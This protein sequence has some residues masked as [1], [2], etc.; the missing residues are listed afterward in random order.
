[1]FLTEKKLTWWEAKEECKQLAGWLVEIKS[2]EQN[3]ALYEEARKHNLVE[4]WIGLSDAG[5]EGEWVWTSGDK[6][7]FLNWTPQSPDNARHNNRMG[8]NCAV[9]RTG[10]TTPRGKPWFTIKKW[11][12]GSC[13]TPVVAAI[14]Q[15]HPGG[16]QEWFKKKNG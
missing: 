14:C 5:K 4:A 7:T 3:D 16:L 1:M 6:A 8:E 15:N 10:A 13:E 11:N 9:L 12:D 2:V